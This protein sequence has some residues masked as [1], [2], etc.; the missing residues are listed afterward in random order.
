MATPMGDSRQRLAASIE[1]SLRGQMPAGASRD[2]LAAAIERALVIEARRSELTLARL[3]AATALAFTVI[4]AGAHVWPGV[5]GLRSFPA[6]AAVFT[7]FWTIGAALLLLALRRGWYRPWLRHILPTIDGL[8]V[9]VIVLLFYG[10]LGPRGEVVPAVAL[11]NVAAL[12]VFLAFSGALRLTHSAAKLATVIAVAV[13]LFAASLFR[14]HPMHV[15]VVSTT[16]VVSGLLA[17]GVTDIVRRVVLGE[18]GRLTLERLYAEAEQ[19]I[20]AR[21]EILSVVSHDLRNPLNT[22]SMSASLMLEMPLPAEQRAKQLQM[23]RRAGQ[24]MQRLIRDL[25]NVAQIEAGRLSIEARP[26]DVASLVAEAAETLGPVAAECSCRL[27]TDVEP[28]LSTALADPARIVQVLTNIVGNAIKFTPPGGQIVIAA[29]RVR[30]KVL[31]SV[32]DTGPGIPEEQLPHIFDRF[33]QAKRVDRRGIGLGLAIVKGIV[34][35]HGQMVWA[36]STVGVGS[37]FYFTLP[38]TDAEVA[39]TGGLGPTLRDEAHAVR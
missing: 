7:G 23:I 3:R 8:V 39:T 27:E 19:A 5:A 13:F 20:L 10:R 9:L 29:K 26:T 33:W 16:L 11:V 6:A 36:V 2:D 25:L 12:C 18:V 4:Y 1:R 30:D 31:C 34:E 15:A 37:T 22:I 38:L 32:A 35:A 17:A 21:E 14:L 28:N 24:R